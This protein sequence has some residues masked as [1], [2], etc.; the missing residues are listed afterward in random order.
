[1]DY[2]KEEL[3]QRFLQHLAQARQLSVHTVRAYGL[4]VENFFSFLKEG[5]L[6]AVN[7]SI[8]RRYLAYLAQ[9][10]MKKKS[11]ARHISSLRTFFNFLLREKIVPSSPVDQIDF[12]KIEKKLPVILTYEQVVRLIEQPD[13]TKLRGVRDRAMMELFYSSALRLSELAHLLKIDVHTSSLQIKVQGKGKKE[14][15][16]PLTK[17]A[18]F[19]IEKYLQHPERE[20]L[21]S[22]Q[23]G[24]LFLNRFGGKISERSIDRNFKDYLRLSGIVG[25]VTPHTIR[26]TIATHWLEK[27]MDLK[28]IQAL[29]GH[30]SLETTTIYTQVSSHLQNKVYE[31]SHPLQQEQFWQKGQEP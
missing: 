14:R 12:P 26:H 7:K 17:Q 22:T 19:W 5:S 2:T 3:K 9:E 25:K 29:L 6:K 28:T 4:D 16:L 27:G 21:E 18:A 31:N 24:Y 8:L 11:V 10:N 1:M 30:S 23:N 15:I 13:I 20:E